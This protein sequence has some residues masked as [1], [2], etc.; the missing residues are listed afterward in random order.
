MQTYFFN[1]IQKNPRRG[2]QLNDTPE[3]AIYGL[4]PYNG[5]V[6]LYKSGGVWYLKDHGIPADGSNT[7]ATQAPTVITGGEY[8]PD[9][10]VSAIAVDCYPES[11][12]PAAVGYLVHFD[13]PTTWNNLDH[14]YPGGAYPRQITKVH[15]GVETTAEKIILYRN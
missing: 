5:Q 9:F 6:E 3:T 1:P 8:V 13:L 12:T 10:V 15:L 2:T 7:H 14:F 4:V 11:G